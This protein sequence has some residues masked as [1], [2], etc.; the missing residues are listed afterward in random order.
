MKKTRL[1]ITGANGMLAKDLLPFFEKFDV[2]AYGK[3]KLD[4]ANKKNT[5]EALFQIRPNIVINCAAFTKVDACELTPECYDVNAT[6]VYN[7]AYGCQKVKSKL[8]HIS[9]DYVFDGQATKFYTETDGRNPLNHYGRSKML[10][11]VAIESLDVK[12]L[13]LRVQWLFGLGGPN[14]VKTML[15][16][17]IS[18]AP[19]LK[20]VNDQF[21]R[22]TSTALLSKAIHYLVTNNATGCY[23]LGALDYC[24]WYDFA[25]EI[26]KKTNKPVVPCTSEEF[27]RPAR[28]PKYS[29]LDI[30]KSKYD[31]APLYTWQEHL[32]SY[33]E[34]ECI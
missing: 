6:G 5:E 11:E 3:E 13:I 16:L 31:N 10:G 20:V 34:T 19:E 14:F 23:H 28:R 32:E 15:K 24:S 22:P 30:E 18:D 27:I 25:C 26:L 21:G 2:Y 9:T 33:L 8:V 12:S 4:I 7:L 17:A 29:V 1:L